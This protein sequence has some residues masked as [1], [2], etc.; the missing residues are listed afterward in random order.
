MASSNSAVKCLNTDP[1]GRKRFVFKSF[2]QRVA[3]INIDVFRSLDPIK[4][5]PT[6]GSSF[7]RE[8]LIQWRELNTAEDFI[9][10]YERMMPLVQTLPQIILHREKIF[11]ELLSRLNMQAHLSLEPILMLIAALSRDILED[12]VPFLERLTKS[13][14]DLLEEGGDRDAAIL[15]QVFTSWSYIMMYLQKY[16]VKDTVNILK[17]TVKLRF[18]SKDYVREFMAEVVSFLLRNAP[19]KQLFTGL[20]KV[21]QEFAKRPSDGRKD[22]VIALLWHVMKGTSERLHSRAERVLRFLLDKSTLFCLNCD[23]YPDGASSV[24]K[25][26]TG[27]LNRLC[28]EIDQNDLGLMYKCVFYEINESIKNDSFVHLNYLIALLSFVLSIT[29]RSKS[30]DKEGIFN[31]VELLINRFIP[32]DEMK[33]DEQLSQVT[34]SI[35]NLLLCLFYV[36]IITSDISRVLSLYAP[37]FQL[38]SPSLL[39]FIK[40]LVTDKAH[41]SHN[42]KD[43][44]IS[45][46]ADFLEN[47]TEQAI[48]ILLKYF[49]NFHEKINTE[50]LKGA[51]KILE[52]FNKKFSHWTEQLNNFSDVQISEDEAALLWGIINCYPKF[53][54][55]QDGPVFVRNLISSID[56]LLKTESDIIAGLPKS[57]WQSLIGSALQSYKELISSNSKGN[58]ELSFFLSLAERNKSSPKILSSFSELFNSFLLEKSL[59]EDE[60]TRIL[61]IFTSNL[62]S[63]NKEIRVSTLRILYHVF[64]KDSNEEQ[65][66]N[67]R[68]K[69][70]E[71]SSEIEEIKCANVAEL[72]LSIE[73]TPLSISTS[74]RITTVLSRIQTEVSSGRFRKDHSKLLLHGILGVLFNRFSQVWDPAVDVLAVLIRGCKDSVWDEFV[75]WVGKRQSEALLDGVVRRKD[76]GGVEMTDLV[77]CFNQY[78]NTESDPTPISTVVIQLL[79]CLQKAS[80]ISESKSRQIVPLFFNF[81]GYNN[82][83]I[84]SVE[85]Y[86][87]DQCKGKDWRFILKEWLNVIKSMHNAR[88]LY[89]SNAL[90]E[91]LVKRLLD[92]VD[93]EIQLK[94]LDCLSNFKHEF[95]APYISHLRNFAASESVR[96]ELT[97]WSVSKESSSIQAEHRSKLVPLIVRIL[98]PKVRNLKSLGSRKHEG[99]SNRKALIRFFMQF[100]PQE[101]NLFFSLLLKPLLSDLEKP[102]DS[103]LI[104]I[105]TLISGNNNDN[106][107]WKRINGF[108]HVFQD[109][110][111]TFDIGHIGPFINNL[112][113]IVVLILENCIKNIKN[114]RA[115]TD[116]MEIDHPSEDLEANVS[117]KQFK[118]LRTLCLRLISLA[119]NKHE[120]HD[121]S[122]NFWDIFFKSVS[123]LINNFKT[124]GAS[125]DKP[126]SLFSCF[127]T[128]SK[129]PNLV[130]LLARQDKLVPTVFSILSVSTASNEI[131]N[132]VLEFVEN[133]LSLDFELGEKEGSFV[134]EVLLPHIDVL[135]Q[136]LHDLYK[137]RVELQRKSNKM[138]IEQR[139]LRIFKMLVN[140]IKDPAVAGYFLD[141]LLPIFRRKDKKERNSDEFVEGLKVVQAMVPILGFEAFNKVLGAINPLLFSAGIELRLCICEIID[142]LASRDSS[143]TVLAKLMRDLN[144]VSQTE[145]D[146][147]D[148]DLRIKAY[149]SISPELFSKLKEEQTMTVLSQC[150]HD[151]SSEE[152][153]FRQSASRALGEFVKFGAGV[154][155]GEGEGGWNKGS[156]GKVVD[157]IYLCHM[158]EAMSKDVSV[159]KEW[160]VLLREMVQ[161]FK[162]HPT[163]SSLN[164][165][166]SE[167]PDHDF[168]TNIVHLQIYRRAKAL[169]LFR[170]KLAT[171]NFSEAIIMKIFVPLIFNMLF[172]IKEIKAD[173]VKTA[174]VETLASISAQ[175]NWESYRFI[176]S[177]SFKELALK[178]SKQKILLRLIC[179]IIDS[180]HFY[181]TISI[182]GENKKIA[183]KNKQYYLEKTVLHKAREIFSQDSD[184]EKVNVNT[185]IVCLKILKLLPAEIMEAQLSSIIHRICT[186]LKNRLESI[187]DEAR[188]ALAACLKELGIEYLSFIVRISRAILKRGYE[189]HVL[190]YTLH[191]LLSKGLG[192]TGQSGQTGRID[193]CLDELLEIVDVDIF[194]EVAEQKDVDKIAGKMK[195]TKKRM[196]FETLRLISQ[197]VTFRTE[198]SRLLSPVSARFTRHLTPGLKGKIEMALHEISI[199]LESN[200]SAEISQLL[201]FVFGLVQDGLTQKGENSN[202]N[203]DLITN[204]ALGLLCNRL[205]KL[206]KEKNDTELLSMLDPFIPLLTQCLN[207]NSSNVISSSFKSL[208]HLIT[209]PL[210]SLDSHSEKIKN[211]LLEISQKSNNSTNNSTNLMRSCL[212][213]LSV[214]LNNSRVRVSISDEELRLIVNFPVFIDLQKSPSQVALSLLKAIINRKLVVPE[215]YDLVIRVGELMVMAHDKPIR[216]V[217]SQILLQFLLD[218]RLSEKRLQQHLDFLLSNLSY[219][220]S[221]GRESV[222]EMLHAI[223]MKFPKT[224]IDNQ[225]QAF[226]LHLVAALSDDRDP[227]IHSMVG[228]VIK[229]LVERTSDGVFSLILEFCVEW[230]CGK[231][232]NLW[233]P[234]AQVLGLLQEAQKGFGKKTD[235]ILNVAKRIM[236]SALD[237]KTEEAQVKNETLNEITVPFWKEAY[238]SVSMLEK[239]FTRSPEMYFKPEMNDIWILVTKF[240]VH[241]YTKL[242]EISTRLISSYFASVPTIKKEEN[243]KNKN[244]N[245]KSDNQSFI[246][247]NPSRLFI[248]S[249]SL[250][251]QL[252][253]ELERETETNN[254]I[255]QNISFLLCELHLFSRERK[256]G[257][258][259]TDLGSTEQS[260][261]IEG[262]KLL[263]SRKAESNFFLNVTSMVERETEAQKEEEKDLRYLLVLPLIK[264]MAKISMQKDDL[265]MEIVFKSF[266]AIVMKLGKEESMIYLHHILF[267]LYKVCEGFAGKVISDQIK[268]LAGEIRDKI[269]NATG[270]DTFV[271]IYNQIR[272]TLKKKR[273][274]R[275]HSDKV[276]AVVNPMKM[277]KKKLRIAAKHKKN[278]RKKVMGMKMGKWKR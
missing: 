42:F 160:F 118:E 129:N 69:S 161:S 254:L 51:K 188:S 259:W 104:E 63:S 177:K 84:K 125:S 240:L 33:M 68:L 145:L 25:V 73:T 36:N 184:K 238:Y 181:E 47:S 41:I 109:V 135:V 58:N 75:E 230:Y 150:V 120:N 138:F 72:L 27:V 251:N 110:L 37:V 39:N 132:S 83:N 205:K 115:E 179:G 116:S 98:T 46:V 182:K 18:Y 187:R 50:T 186:F 204:F 159:Q 131:I 164:S 147:A 117:A 100:E 14:V 4:S 111:E 11:S 257:H 232:R 94:V 269:R 87:A 223:L 127:I 65:R 148:Y 208:S 263:G 195:E 216:T 119:L 253:T 228:T 149:D 224:I 241:P 144:A 10:F 250:I 266:G 239:I 122:S 262:F 225:A 218:Y 252:K 140:Y 128:M 197:N 189:L 59:Q 77:Q 85:S 231:D 210:P 34:E 28:T 26:L 157:R 209:L 29:N 168:F 74:R 158:G 242:R 221:S 22:G 45:S 32:S 108:L 8:T 146:E 206:K 71:S 217:S 236:E 97:T 88:S 86:K 139:E 222:L 277:A 163:L 81:L 35:L 142:G 21:V 152:L 62:S 185:S 193:Y 3:E 67:K 207:S 237:T 170:K 260:C 91:V 57:T 175:V 194:G 61:S 123:P 133:L 211:S 256:S 273:E 30:L 173:H 136:S 258:F 215:I 114:E 23:K 151:M 191:F 171:D 31:I 226:F 271:Q 54:N 13:I 66:P 78:I 172:D 212:K 167:D 44:I 16:L 261:F 174:C 214:L 274:S 92:D 165:L 93:S 265:Q 126:S 70:E 80:D 268:Q 113:M 227:Q 255:L 155:N 38:R 199:G 246:L 102:L 76:D 90:H 2:S 137:I 141:I 276:L 234:A 203:S 107:S 130:T 82:A 143:L 53:C 200:P 60:I 95:L 192:L 180:F 101:L 178:P 248:I 213:L 166:C 249:I 24:N 5:E 220:H 201:V 264:R 49:A 202:S 20:R 106:L 40:E 278:K 183:E 12:F 198:A 56:Q 134:K 17:V 9:T 244:K 272:K 99:L 275:K 247:Q 15:E 121:F 48:F 7:F 6:V 156:V 105:S 219:E 154:W 112:M 162:N 243:T 1:G 96:E 176:L 43:Q 124:E 233:S 190:G 55:L 103:A 267:P 89:Q 79:K 270:T 19:E 64:P 196:S 229:E 169:S 153:I 52:F 235:T 245:K